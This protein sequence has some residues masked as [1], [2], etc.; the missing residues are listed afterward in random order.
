MQIRA[1]SISKKD[2]TQSP[3]RHYTWSL[4]GQ[5]GA[6]LS[7]RLRLIAVSVVQCVFRAAPVGKL[8]P[9]AVVS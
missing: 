7:Q 6:K 1:Y 8:G 4:R 9:P 2:R 5:L 3:V